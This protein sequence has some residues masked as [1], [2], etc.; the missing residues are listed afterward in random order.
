MII[1]TVISTVSLFHYC[2]ESDENYV[3]PLHEH[4]AYSVMVAFQFLCT[5]TPVFAQ[6]LLVSD[7]CYNEGRTIVLFTGTIN[8]WDTSM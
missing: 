6:K 2:E 4:I 8:V 5:P 1:S 3:N 7:S